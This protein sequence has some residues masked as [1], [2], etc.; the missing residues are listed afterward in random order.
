MHKVENDCSNKA[1]FD[2]NQRYVQVSLC[3]FLLLHV[4]HV[5]TPFS[6]PHSPVLEPPMTTMTCQQLLPTAAPA[7]YLHCHDFITAPS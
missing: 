1:M 4:Q 3:L 5:L 2:N 6:A 7:A